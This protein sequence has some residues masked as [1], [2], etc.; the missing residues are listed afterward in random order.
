MAKTSKT[1]R[2]QAQCLRLPADLVAR[3]DRES[4]R[5]DMPK[6]RIVARALRLYFQRIDERRGKR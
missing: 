3:L 6:V 5:T 1:D 2:L 4:L